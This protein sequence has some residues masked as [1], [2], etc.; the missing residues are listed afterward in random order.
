MGLWSAYFFAKLLLYA[1]GHIGFHPWLNLGLAV[2]TALP[3]RNRQ[4]RF[5]RNLLAVPLGVMLLYHDSWL[6]PIERVWAQAGNLGAF[7][8]P[9]LLELLGRF[10]D[11]QVL[12]MLGLLFA[13]YSLAR[14]KL[15][16]ST[17][18]FIAIFALIL[19]PSTPELLRAPLSP[20]ATATIS[21]TTSAPIDPRNL[22][23]DALDEMLTQFHAKEAKRLVRFSATATRQPFD[24]LL[25]HICSLSWEDLQTAK[26]LD[27][28]LL[29][30]FDILLSKFNSAASYS[31]PAAIRLLRGN[32]G[33][34]MHR[35]L[36]DPAARE[37]L[38]IDMLDNAG[39]E[40]H[41]LMNHDGR[42]G[43]FLA[44]VR[45]RG[46]M[47]VPLE[48]IPS[49]AKIAQQSFDGS[50]IYDDYSTLSNWWS[51]RVA[52]PAAQI[53]LYYNTTSL[54][55]G[56][57]AAGKSGALAYG[58]RLEQ[59]T[60]G[61]ARFLDELDRSGRRVI[62]VFVPE[63]GAALRGDRKQIPGL[64]EIPTPAITQVPVGVVLINAPAG[65]RGQ[66]RIDAPTSYLAM[67]ELLSR[68]VADNPFARQTPGLAAYTQN[69]PQ[70]DLVSENEGTLIMQIGAQYMLRTPDGAWSSWG[71]VASPTVP[72][73]PSPD[74]AV[75][76]LPS[77]PPRTHG[78]DTA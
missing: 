2:F 23:G 15:R 1:G 65:E 59:F 40:P 62:V 49:G 44:D 71:P 11:W 61:I 27:D 63:H 54:H 69:L 51:Q 47:P 43:D 64:R 17:F 33:Q 52:N 3:P 77:E 56:N 19:L 8:L 6:P 50:P 35:R 58:P 7:T 10:I 72:H 38:L 16:L 32:C 18:V 67:N 78:A 73:T 5:A 45:E 31:G 39:F 20:A 53:V 29:Q 4:Q 26:R 42:F 74:E 48:R 36:Y 55:D 66:L 13:V 75:L 37:C 9:Y 28:P 24:I 76:R 25:L 14:R 41:W 12:A 21:G 60:A 70:T 30:R 46:A 68:F 57:R 22:R 34:A